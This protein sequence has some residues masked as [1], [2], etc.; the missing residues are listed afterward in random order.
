MLNS[1]GFFLEIC[2]GYFF[3]IYDELN[4]GHSGTFVLIVC[5]A[6]LFRMSV[7]WR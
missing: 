2:L 4:I 5:L 3:I 7:L 1:F 6:R